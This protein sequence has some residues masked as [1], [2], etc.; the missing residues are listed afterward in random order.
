M[1]LPVAI[2]TENACVLPGE[3]PASTNR[4]PTASLS[5]ASVQVSE[6]ADSDD[7]AVELRTSPSPNKVSI[8]HLLFVYLKYM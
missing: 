1:V 4:Q 6:S 7:S 2:G 5:G 8:Y 3:G